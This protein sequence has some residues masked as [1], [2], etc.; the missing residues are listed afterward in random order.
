MSAAKFEEDKIYNLASFYPNKNRS[1]HF[2]ELVNW[3]ILT[4]GIRNQGKIGRPISVA[5]K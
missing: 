1:E 5:Q 4:R 2:D 3:T